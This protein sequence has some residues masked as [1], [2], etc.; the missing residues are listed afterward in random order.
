MKKKLLYILMIPVFMF[1][2]SCNEDEFLTQVNPNSITT[3]VYWETSDDFE[4]G[5]YTVYGA[6]QFPSISGAQF[7]NNW[8]MGDL[9]G[10]ESWMKTFEF[11]TLNFN[12]ASEHV[13]NKWNELYVG[14]FRANQVIEYIQDAE[15]SSSEKA[16]IVAQARFLRAFFYFE[17][18]HSYGGAVIHTVVPVT[19]EDF[20]KAFDSI[21]KVT[22][23]VIIPDLEFAKANLEGVEWTGD[24]LGRATW[25]AATAL[26]GKVYLYNKDW[27]NA[28]DEFKKIIDSGIYSLTPDFMD[29]FTDENEF[30]SE[31]IFEVAYSAVAGDTGANGNNIDTTPNEIGSEANTIDAKVGQLNSGGYNEVL[32]SY[33]L[34]ELLYNDEIDP[35]KGINNGFTQSQRMYASVLTKDGDGSYFSVPVTELKGF[36]FAQTAYVKKYTNW[37]QYDLINTTNPRSGINIRHI[38]YSDV[39][40]MYAE[41]ILNAQGDAAAAEA[42]TY[43]DRIRARAGVVTLQDYL[44]NNANTFP[45]M[46]VS[47]VVNGAYNLVAPTADNLLTH[48]MMVERPIELCFEGHRWK[49]LT[50]WGIVK[51]VLTARRADELWLLANWDAIMNTAPFYFVD[52]AQKVRTDYAVCAA[53]YTPSAHDYLPIPTDERQI[54]SALGN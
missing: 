11:V 23:D 33:Y 51:E 14:I 8:V 22:T 2:T 39:L 48:I 19:D 21:D 7:T 47:K 26:M 34:H 29:N 9:A 30:N 35:T 18:A 44:N 24:D 37:Y 25:G 31:S 17:L 13:K 53:S 54:N 28:A 20:Q 50:R 42:L 41:A 3:D 43:I 36:G 5:L 45:A 46:H 15:I 10:A 49:D 6:L 38:R 52:E 12:D 40:L 32:G 4:K 27:V 16:L 1:T